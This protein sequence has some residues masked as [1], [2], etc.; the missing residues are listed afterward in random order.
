M[1][2]P[3]EIIMLLLKAPVISFILAVGSGLSSNG[4][5]NIFVDANP[6]QYIILEINTD[7]KKE[8][9]LVQFAD[10]P[11]SPKFHDSHRQIT[12]NIIEGD[13]DIRHKNSNIIEKDDEIRQSNGKPDGNEPGAGSTSREEAKEMSSS[14]ENVL[15]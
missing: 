6:A 3:N 12:S 5:S 2:L 11:Q 13:D 10:Q 4:G 15:K 14:T 7:S 9:Y 8:V 1:W